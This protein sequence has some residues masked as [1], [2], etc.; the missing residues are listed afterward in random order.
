MVTLFLIVDFILSWKFLLVSLKSWQT[1]PINNVLLLAHDLFK[2]MNNE[3]GEIIITDNQTDEIRDSD[4]P[5]PAD[6]KSIYSEVC[7]TCMVS[8]LIWRYGA[9]IMNLKIHGYCDELL[10]VFYL[11]DSLL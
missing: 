7:S 10:P 8:Y 6:Q 4:H 3:D 5:K 2:V 1:G 11:I 9:S